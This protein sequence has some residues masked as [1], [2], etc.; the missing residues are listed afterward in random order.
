MRVHTVASDARGP[1]SSTRAREAI[2]SGDLEQARRVLSRPHAVSGVVVHGHERG[3]TIGV[4]TANLGDIP[5]LLPPHGVYA[6]RVERSP[7]PDQ[8]FVPLARGVTNVGV[9][10][11]VGGAERVVSVE[12]HLLDFDGDLYDA[13]LRVH[14][15]ARLREEKK[16]G[17]LD[18]LKEQ[19]ARDI[20][21]ARSVTA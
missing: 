5:E 6:V 18:E 4:P 12:T 21:A 20:A 8:P 13:R 19:I 1:Y 11:T 15:L 16:F 9:R 14:L 7:G 3:R 10:P 2:A 17:S